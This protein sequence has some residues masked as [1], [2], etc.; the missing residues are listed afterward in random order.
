MEKNVTKR[1][2]ETFSSLGSKLVEPGWISSGPHWLNKPQMTSNVTTMTTVR[3][4]LDSNYWLKN[5][6]KWGKKYRY[7]SDRMLILPI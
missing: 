5:Y 4:E 6:T 1:R 3:G 7:K 2:L